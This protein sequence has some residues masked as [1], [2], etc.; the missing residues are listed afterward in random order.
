MQTNTTLIPAEQWDEY[1]RIAEQEAARRIALGAPPTLDYSE[2]L[3]WAL[4]VVTRKA[5][6]P[7]DYMRRAI[8]HAL[9][10]A[11]RSERRR[12]RHEVPIPLNLPAR[13]L[14]YEDQGEPEWKEA[15]RELIPLID[16]SSPSTLP[17]VLTDRQAL[18]IRLVYY[19]GMKHEEA[20]VVMGC[21]RQIVGKLLCSALRR[22]KVALEKYFLRAPGAFCK[23]GRGNGCK[24]KKS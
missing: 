2:L 6:V 14:N 20:A 19:Q 7:G 23:V 5:G 16:G 15:G 8:R 21:A 22:L 11:M 10:S 12:C 9:I 13:E 24:G 3:S 18:A 17:C 1:V 4:V